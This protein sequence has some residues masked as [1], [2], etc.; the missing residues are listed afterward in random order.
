MDSSKG[1]AIK[2]RIMKSIL[3]ALILILMMGFWLPQCRRKKN[4]EMISYKIGILQYDKKSL[5]IVDRIKDLVSFNPGD[6]S[7]L[8]MDRQ[9]LHSK[10]EELVVDIQNRIDALNK[11]KAVYEN[12][13][14][15]QYYSKFNDDSVVSDLDVLSEQRDVLGKVKH[16]ILQGNKISDK[17]YCEFH[18]L[19][20]NKTSLITFKESWYRT[21]CALHMTYGFFESEISREGEFS[22]LYNS[23]EEYEYCPFITVP[24]NSLYSYYSIPKTTIRKLVKDLDSG[25]SKQFKGEADYLKTILAE[26]Y[27]SEN[28]EIV[29][30]FEL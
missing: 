29:L 2:C 13:Q 20:L 24:P 14:F 19:Y 22:N 25:I 5:A 16:D 12:N 9:N 15:V 21:D 8:V 17:E 10:I 4:K 7:Y 3:R 28:I 23:L 18:N 26:A 30:S 27:S 11:K 6:S 1:N